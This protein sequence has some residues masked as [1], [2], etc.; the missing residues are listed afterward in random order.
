MKTTAKTLPDA[1]TT[2]RGVRAASAPEL[3]GTQDKLNSG[4]QQKGWVGIITS[5]PHSSHER[6]YNRGK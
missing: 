5:G 4:K 2:R 3:Q 1:K 6:I